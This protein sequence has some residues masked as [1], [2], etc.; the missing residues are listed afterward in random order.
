MN[1]VFLGIDQALSAG[2]K[3]PNTVKLQFNEEKIRKEQ[4]K[5]TKE[6]ESL[7]D[8]VGAARCRPA[9]SWL[10]AHFAVLPS[11]DPTASQGGGEDAVHSARAHPAGIR[12]AAPQGTAPL[13][14]APCR[15]YLNG[16]PPCC[17]PCQDFRDARYRNDNTIEWEEWARRNPDKARDICLEAEYFYGDS[18]V[19]PK[20]W[21]PILE[22]WDKATRGDAVVD[23]GTYQVQTGASGDMVLAAWLTSC[24][25]HCP[26]SPRS[27]MTRTI[28]PPSCWDRDSTTRTI[29]CNVLPVVRCPGWSLHGS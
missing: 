18:N 2:K 11:R 9:L 26:C 20:D 5:W 3:G 7:Q 25:T 29:S 27:R 14:L 15:A 28:A 19:L 4:E 1:A 22:K 16:P 8:K 21:A 6:A 23:D 24:C 12:G 17:F 13:P 10:C